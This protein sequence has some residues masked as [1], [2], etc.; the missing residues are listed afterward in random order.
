MPDKKQVEKEPTKQELA[1][2]I[3]NQLTNVFNVARKAVSLNRDETIKILQVEEWT[4]KS[5]DD[6]IKK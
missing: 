5:I 6:L 2:A 1:D 4:L 3:K